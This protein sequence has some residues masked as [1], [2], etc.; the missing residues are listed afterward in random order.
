MSLL[1]L[2]S[3]ILG[4]NT[5][6]RAIIP[7]FTFF[8]MSALF[9]I[10]IIFSIKLQREKGFKNTKYYLFAIRIRHASSQLHKWHLRN[11][12]LWTH[13]FVFMIV[14]M[15]VGGSCW[16]GGWCCL[17]SFPA[18]LHVTADEQLELYFLF[19]LRHLCSKEVT[20]AAA[21]F[22]SLL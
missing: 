16:C 13:S 20:E 15:N 10:L 8:Y 3:N 11:F 19:S 21:L 5:N 2:F 18:S 6:K 9:S 1:R 14:I 7:M 4:I 22:G 12:I 17:A